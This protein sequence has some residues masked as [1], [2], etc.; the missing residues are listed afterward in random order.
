MASV[1]T[2]GSEPERKVRALLRELGIRYRANV[3]SLPG[4]PDLVLPDLRRVV[5]V[6]GC[7]WHGHHCKHG[8][9]RPATNAAFWRAKIAA[10]GT[11]DRRV[12]RRLRALGWRVSVV[13][14]CEL[15]GGMARLRARLRRLAAGP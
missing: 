10:N 1:R 4:T 13:W 5:F 11:R 12:A 6:H 9:T 15:R 8:S 2:T 14:Q 7:F 3:R